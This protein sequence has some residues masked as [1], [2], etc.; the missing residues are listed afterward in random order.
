MYVNIRERE[1]VSQTVRN[2]CKVQD[3]VEISDLVA[4][5]RTGY[6][7]FLQAKIVPTR[8]KK[9]G[10]ELLFSEIFPVTNYDK[11]MTLDFLYYE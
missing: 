8:R 10:L 9:H 11:T 4:I 3:A 5:Q 1:M 2:F 6:E 7:N